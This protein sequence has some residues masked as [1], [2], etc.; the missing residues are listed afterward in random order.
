MNKQLANNSRQTGKQKLSVVP[1]VSNV[2][3][4]LSDLAPL[5]ENFHAK[6]RSRKK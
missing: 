5:R 2:V 6:P 4:N 3:Q 1:Y